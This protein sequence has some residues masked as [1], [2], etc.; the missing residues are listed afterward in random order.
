MVPKR[1]VRWRRVKDDTF[2]KMA[3]K[4]RRGIIKPGVDVRVKW[5]K[6]SKVVL[7]QKKEYSSFEKKMARI[8]GKDDM[9][10]IWLDDYSASVWLLIDGKR[11][12][13]HIGEELVKEYGE[14][15][16]PL[17]P[18]LNKFLNTLLN[19][20]LIIFYRQKKKKQD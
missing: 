11:N 6:E 15:A 13:E 16:Q 9:G 18:R 8:L 1:N 19:H 3:R 20:E 17:Y 4:E 7:Y 10:R 2:K 12:V 14:D 5:I